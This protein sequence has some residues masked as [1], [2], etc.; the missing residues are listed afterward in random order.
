[1]GRRGGAG[2]YDFLV[3]DAQV[4]DGTGSPWYQADVAVR[5][6]RIA[7][8]GR[9]KGQA[10]S[11]TIQADGL[12][13]CPGFVDAHVHGDAVM[14]GDPAMEAAVRQ[15]V[16]TFIIGQDGI[17]FAPASEPTMTYMR[18]YFAALNGFYDL[19]Y[20]WASVSEYLARFDDR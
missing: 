11:R 16:T 2:V 20:D 8:I 19:G 6:G 18:E 5:D 13:L 7:A 12:V 1:G 15:G 3:Q 14:L 10:A 17:G 4:V 9:L